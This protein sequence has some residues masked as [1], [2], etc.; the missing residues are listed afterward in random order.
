M[1]IAPEEQN[2]NNMPNTYTKIYI[3][4]IF[5]PM[6]RECNIHPKWENE[7]QKYITGIVQNNG[8]KMLAVNG[9]PDHVHVFFGMK[10]NQSLSEL[11]RDIKANSSKWINERKFVKGKFA[12]QEGYGGFSY[13]H[14][15]LNN[16]INYINNQKIHHKKRNFRDEYLGFLKKFDVDFNNE[17]LFEFFE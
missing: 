4:V 7:L 11:V 8:H 15:Q 12:W 5:S 16:V 14:S 2:Y 3:Q 9:M 10:P 13:G 6:Y 17:Y 1:F